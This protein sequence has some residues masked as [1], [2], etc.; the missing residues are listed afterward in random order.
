MS[1]LVDSL[2]E[3][4][5]RF[6]R[7]EARRMFGGHGVY[8]EG[9]MFALVAQDTLYLKADAKTLPAFDA[10]GLAPFSFQ[11][12]DKTMQ[13][14]YRQAP[15]DLFEDRDE[16]ARWARLAYET[17]LRSGQAPR[18]KTKSTATAASRKKVTR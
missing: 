18:A 2:P 9:R 6:G 11:R 16:A 5:E 4:F 12:G 15:A 14:S 10:L 13:M 1:G 8:H 3:V 17:A 7:V